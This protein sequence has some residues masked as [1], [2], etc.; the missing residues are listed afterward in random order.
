M[1]LSAIRTNSHAG[2]S[3]NNAGLVADCDT[4]A[5]TTIDPRIAAT[6]TTFGVKPARASAFITGLSSFWNLGF[7]S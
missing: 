6:V 1:A 5:P 2:S 4:T 3:S 7:R